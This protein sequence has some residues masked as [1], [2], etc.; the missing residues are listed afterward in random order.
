MDRLRTILILRGLLAAFFVVLGVVL[1]AGG[2][3][4]FGLFAVAVG[5]VNAALIGV[6]AHRARRQPGYHGG[7]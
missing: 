6:V 2:D 4:V 7:D 1:L 3:T 5:V